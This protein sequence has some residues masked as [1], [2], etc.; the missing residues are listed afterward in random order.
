ICL[1]KGLTGGFL[2]LSATV[3]RDHIHDAFLGDS[4][5][6]AFLH[7]HSFTANPLGC[8]AALASL[9]LLEAP[10]CGQRRAGIERLHRARLPDLAR[11]PQVARPR[12]QGTIAA[13]DIMAGEQGYGASIGG[14]LKAWFLER[15]LLLRPLGN[16]LYLLPPYCV[17]DADLDRAYDAI[18]ACLIE[19]SS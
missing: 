1:S 17:E 2:P 6:K 14:R 4:L 16:V 12:V 15:G 9:D 5:G 19:L 18:A 3:C 7:G 8:A 11:L 13:F 10:S